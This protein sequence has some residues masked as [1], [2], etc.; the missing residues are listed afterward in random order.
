M[1]IRHAIA[2]GTN[3][4]QMVQRIVDPLNPHPAITP[5]DNRIFMPTQSE[6]QDTSGGLGAFNPAKAEALLAA[7]GM[8]MGSDGYFHPTSGPEQGKDFAL[9][10]TTSGVPVRAWR[11]RSSSRPT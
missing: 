8:K 4:A 10:I 9:T 1:G 5:L 6:Y 3:R 7:N 2:Y 11:S